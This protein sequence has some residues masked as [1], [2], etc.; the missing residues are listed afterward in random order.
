MQ[1]KYHSCTNAA[2]P[3]KAVAARF[4]DAKVWMCLAYLKYWTPILMPLTV[5]PEVLFHPHFSIKA[6]VPGRTRAEKGLLDSRFSAGEPALM[7]SCDGAG[8]GAL[9][10]ATSGCLAASACLLTA[11]RSFSAAS[12]ADFRAACSFE[13][14]S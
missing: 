9:G 7:G 6:S 11:C 12:D 1:A 10:R 14:A 8:A 2:P 5:Y 4:P 3:T 13:T